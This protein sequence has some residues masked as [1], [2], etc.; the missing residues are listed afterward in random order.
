MTTHPPRDVADACGLIS[1]RGVAA[2]LH[3]EAWRVGMAR[4]K[5]DYR[6]NGSGILVTVSV[7]LRAWG[8]WVPT[9]IVIGTSNAKPVQPLP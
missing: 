6:V 1:H 5:G 2:T 3:C 9:P 8:N 4:M 7:T